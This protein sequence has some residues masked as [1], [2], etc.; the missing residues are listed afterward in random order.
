M[1][2]CLTTD[3]L[4][5]FKDRIYV[6]HNIELKKVILKVFHAKPYSSHQCYQKTVTEVKRFYY[7]SNL[8]RDVVEFVARCFDYQQV[9]AK[10]KTPCGMLQWIAILE[11]KWVL[12]SMDFITD[13]QGKQDIMIPSWLLW[14]G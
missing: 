2:Y 4:V 11:W 13:C 3:G 1:D 10:C 8:N 14:I 7:W 12:I 5:R 9:K 6:L